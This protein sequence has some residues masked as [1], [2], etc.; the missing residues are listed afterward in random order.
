MAF[1]QSS[2]SAISNSVSWELTNGISTQVRVAVEAAKL[3][4]AN[5]PAVR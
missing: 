1:D 2:F 5:E 3:E 4:R